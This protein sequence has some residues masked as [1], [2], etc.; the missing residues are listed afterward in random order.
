MGKAGAARKLA[1]AAVYGGGGLSLLGGALYGLLTAEAQLA[2]RAIGVTGDARPPDATGW[3]GRGRPGP[4]VKIAL[5]G[6]S[7]AAG[8]GCDRVEALADRL[9]RQLGLGPQHAVETGAQ[10]GQPASAVRRGGRELARCRCLAHRSNVLIG[11]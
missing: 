4:A 5:L 7:S 10:G 8:Y 3:Y 11:N 1:S 9:A 2:R 6:D